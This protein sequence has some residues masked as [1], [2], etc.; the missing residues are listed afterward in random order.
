MEN[1]SLKIT[2]QPD[3]SLDILDTLTNHLFTGQH[4]FEESG[5]SG[6][7]W[8]HMAP[9][10]D[11]VITSLGHKAIVECLEASDL[12]TRYRVRVVLE[13]PAGLE[14][15]SRSYRRTKQA[16]SLPIESTLTLRKGQRWLDVQTRIDNRAE[17]HRVRACF[18]TRIA[19]THSAA[20]AAFDVIE[21]PITITPDSA[22]FGKTNPQYPM[23]RFVDMS[24]GN[25]G[26]A[27]LNEG[28]REYEATDDH[29]RTLYLTLLRGFTAM[30]SP[31]IDQWDVY[32]WMKLSQSLG[33]NECHYAIMPHADGWLQG[34]LYEAAE[35]FELPLESA[36]AGKGG[37]DMPKQ[38]SFLEISPPDVV[39][40]AL[41]KCEHRDSLVLRVYNPTSADILAQVTCNTQVQDAWL[42]NMNEERRE[43]LVVKDGMIEVSMPHK[44]IVTLEFAFSQQP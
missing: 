16:V 13:V 8:I 33:I 44:K 6:H 2:I 43:K 30:Q 15:E 10:Q 17:Q 1:E 40:S 14:G 7:A 35:Q 26:L 22:Y 25:V 19:A 28:M 39:L 42:T 9:E 18:P 32:P 23:H 5:E 3:G 41:K 38:F 4:Y 29:D 20:E 11:E 27:L 37:G 36:Q 31:V 21:R 24:D 12:L 34:R